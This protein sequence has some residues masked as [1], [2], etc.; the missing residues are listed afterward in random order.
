MWDN[1]MI[2]YGGYRFPYAGS[3]YS[4]TGPGGRGSGVEPGVT[5]SDDVLRYRF[6]SNAWDVLNTSAAAYAEEE[7]ME[8]E[9]GSGTGV[10]GNKTVVRVPLLPAPRYGHSAV[11]Y[12]VSRIFREEFGPW[13]PC[14]IPIM[15]SSYPRFYPYPYPTP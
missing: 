14:A 8:P 9:G 7:V 15:I 3:V 6:D 12:N 2:V 1:T 4:D 11:V 10:G 5:V 13:F